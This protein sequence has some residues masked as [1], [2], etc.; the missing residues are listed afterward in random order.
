MKYCE[1][2]LDLPCAT[3]NSP[4]SS[5]VA[6]WAVPLKRCMVALHAFVFEMY[7]KETGIFNILTVRAL[8][9]MMFVWHL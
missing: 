5:Y 9:I 6:A 3:G 1:S 2:L 8:R 4:Q 7:L